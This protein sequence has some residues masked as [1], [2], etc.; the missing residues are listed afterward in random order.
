MTGLNRSEFLTRAGAA[1]AG[2]LALGRLPEAQARAARADDGIEIAAYYFPQFHP[3]PRNDGWHGAG[4]TEWEIVKRGEPRFAGHR[5]PNLPARGFEDESDPRVFERKIDAAAAPRPERVHLRLVLVREPAVPQRR[6]RPRLPRGAQHQPP[7]V[8]ADVGQPR[9]VGPVSAQARDAAVH[10][11]AGGAGRRPRTRSGGRPTTSS[12]ATWATRRTGAS[13]AART[14]RSTTS[15]RSRPALGGRAETRA[16]L[17]GF[18]DRARAAGH[19]E[20]HLTRSSPSGRRSR[21]AAH[22]ARLRQRHPLHVDPPRVRRADRDRTPYS[23]LREL[24]PRTW[25][26]LDGELPVPYIP[27]VSMGWDPSPRTAQ[28]DVYEHIGYPFTPVLRRQHA[29]GVPPRAGQ[30]ARVPAR[31]RRPAHRHRQRLERMARGQLPRARPPHGM[32]YLKR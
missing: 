20:L 12:S 4:W 15:A 31:P 23:K 7:E 25:A 32:A 18:R 6:A 16:L 19:G 22:G 29:A 11:A 9:L 30:P 3:D 26:R 1:A 10:A 14:S 5:Q 17:D 21:A 2:A 24:A 8:R 13:K 28:S 27:T